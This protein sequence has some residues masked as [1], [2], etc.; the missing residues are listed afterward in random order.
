MIYMKYLAKVGNKTEAVFTK[1][2]PSEP[3]SQDSD[4]VALGCS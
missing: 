3:F 4:S 1:L 2:W